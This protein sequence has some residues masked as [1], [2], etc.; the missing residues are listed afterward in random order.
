MR[1][2]AEAGIW[3]LSPYFPDLERRA[4]KRLPVLDKKRCRSDAWSS[5]SD[6]RVRHVDLGAT[7]ARSSHAAAGN[8]RRRPRP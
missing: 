1:L 2:S 3:L 5:V 8:P 6:Y 7:G 4:E